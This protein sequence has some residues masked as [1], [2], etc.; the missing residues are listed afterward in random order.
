MYEL[1]V[2]FIA[3][4]LAGLINSIAGGGA[5]FVYPLLLSLG[6]SPINANATS[7][8]T[9]WPGAL[10]SAFGYRKFLKKMPRAYFWLLIPSIIGAIIGAIILRDTPNQNFAVIVPWLMLLGVIMIW[11]QP[12]IKGRVLKKTKRSKKVSIIN[13]T[14]I[15][16]PVFG[17]AIYGGYFGAGFGVIM[18]AI[19]GFTHLSDIH[20]MNGL[21]NLSGAV[22]NITASFYFVHSGLVNWKYVPPLLIGTI[23]GGYLGATYS[24]KLPTEAIRKIII[25]SG[26]LV[27]IYLFIK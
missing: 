19:L 1:I 23:M 11:L 20:Q 25:I 10:S 5:L 7:T 13:L 4:F 15:S 2:L 9:V 14:L 3:G 22:I 12:S 17:M 16:I 18:L 26:I 8:M 27:A 21:K 24:N 6:L